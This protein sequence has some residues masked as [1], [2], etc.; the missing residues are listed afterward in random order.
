MKHI[1]SSYTKHIVIIKNRLKRICGYSKSVHPDLNALKLDSEIVLNIKLSCFKPLQMNSNI[2]LLLFCI[3]LGLLNIFKSLLISHEG[4]WLHS[5]QFEPQGFHITKVR[6]TLLLERMRPNT[7]LK[8]CLFSDMLKK[9]KKILN[10]SGLNPAA[11]TTEEVESKVCPRGSHSWGGCEYRVSSRH[12]HQRKH[13]HI[14][15]GD[16]LPL[17]FKNKQTQHVL[18]KNQFTPYSFINKHITLTLSL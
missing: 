11:M 12:M 18:M 15:L 8:G 1:L 16:I 9:Y 7:Q 2:T 14:Q 5:C 10:I 6:W 17:G 4:L 13:R 3:L